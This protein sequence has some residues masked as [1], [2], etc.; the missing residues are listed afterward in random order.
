MTTK[1]EEECTNKY[2]TTT[3][4]DNKR[5][6]P[7]CDD[8]QTE[9]EMPASESR[10]KHTRDDTQTEQ[11][12]CSTWNTAT[13]GR[14][15]A[16]NPM[17]ISNKS[18]VKFKRKANSELNSAEQ[19][20]RIDNYFKKVEGKVKAGLETNT[21]ELDDNSPHKGPDQMNNRQYKPN[22]TRRFLNS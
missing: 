21:F 12:K 17:Q 3:K 16:R 2:T 11:K 10:D 15:Q 19:I 13:S 1:N 22:N 4:S 9:R 8:T 6:I 20:N 7:T 5:D 18:K 14:N